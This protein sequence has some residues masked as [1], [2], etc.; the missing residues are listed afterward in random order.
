MILKNEFKI[1]KIRFYF[2]SYDLITDMLLH[3]S[4]NFFIIILFKILLIILP[5]C[6]EI[7]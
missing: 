7:Q 3:I 5:I 4:I 1:V 6:K 2:A